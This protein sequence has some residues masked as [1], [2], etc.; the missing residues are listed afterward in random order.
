MRG[1]CPACGGVR[2]S[3]H[4]PDA[5]KL[6]SPRVHPKP[7]VAPGAHFGRCEDCE[8]VFLADGVYHEA[9]Y[10]KS[11]ADPARHNWFFADRRAHVEVALSAMRRVTGKKKLRI[12]DFGCAYGNVTRLFIER[13]HEAVGYDVA[14]NHVEYARSQ[15]GVEAYSGP[16][17]EARRA[18]G[19]V[20]V[21][22]SENVF[23]HIPDPF[24]TLA[25]VSKNLEGGGVAYLSVPNF[26]SDEVGYVVPEH[27]HYFCPRSLVR[28][29]E[30]A[31]LVV[32]SCRWGR[33]GIEKYHRLTGRIPP[34]LLVRSV[35]W[36]TSRVGRHGYSIRLCAA[37]R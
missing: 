31:G 10:V 35:D 4:V 24:E 25:D 6:T 1:N 18:I 5:R 7:V 21:I 8:H 17:Q 27:L 16:W 12:L 13:G 11:E 34:M 3:A 22:Y 15:H 14:A 23:E 20:D 19:L 29:V 9:D 33:P 32:V 36:L 28:L 2:L 26:D 37:R 30:R